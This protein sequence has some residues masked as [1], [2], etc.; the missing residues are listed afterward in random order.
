MHTA[1]IIYIYI[2]DII[3]CKTPRREKGFG[4]EEV[5][6]GAQVRAGDNVLNNLS[7]RCT[8][9]GIRCQAA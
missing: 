6:R 5:C 8:P 9:G 1:D 4:F 7:F 2:Y 3:I